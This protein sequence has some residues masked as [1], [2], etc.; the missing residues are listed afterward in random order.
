[1]TKW[2]RAEDAAARVR[3]SAPEWSDRESW[4]WWVF[5]LVGCAF[6]ARAIYVLAVGDHNI[7][8]EL[9][10]VV[11]LATVVPACFVTAKRRRR[12]RRQEP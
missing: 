3:R 1:M 2:R 9:A 10:A 6:G 7:G 5:A 8:I 4:P 12:A 11:V